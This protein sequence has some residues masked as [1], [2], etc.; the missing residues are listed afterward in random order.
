MR[1]P[2]CQ[3]IICFFLYPTC[4]M[5]KRT[6]HYLLYY[7]YHYKI[8]SHYSRGK[9]LLMTHTS[10]L[11]AESVRFGFWV[12]CQLYI[13]RRDLRMNS[14]GSSPL[15]HAAEIRRASGRDQSLFPVTRYFDRN[16]QFTGLDRGQSVWMLIG[17]DRLHFFLI[18]GMFSI[19]RWHKKWFSPG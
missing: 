7:R 2:V 4:K 11:V 1:Q 10:I 13:R 19:K 18:N 5:T 3:W 16:V 14:T 15:F 6:P 17:S 9:F 12:V 8:T